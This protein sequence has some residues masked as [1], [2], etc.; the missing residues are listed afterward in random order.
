MLHDHGARFPAVSAALRDASA[1]Q[2]APQD[3]AWEFGL[4]RILDGLA[5]LVTER[6][7]G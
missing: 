4:Q 7:P 1:D 2:A 5:T 6:S 3:Q